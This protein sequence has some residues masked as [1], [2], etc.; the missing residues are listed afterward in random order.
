MEKGK[1]NPGLLGK[2][3]DQKLKDKISEIGLTVTE[4]WLTKHGRKHENPS[5]KATINMPLSKA[6]YDLIPAMWRKP[7]SVSKTQGLAHSLDITLDT[8]DGGFFFLGA[9]TLSGQPTRFRKQRHRQNNS[10]TR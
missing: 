2:I 7:D 10:D 8:L 9:D 4:Q 3:E 5:K 1:Y 6:D